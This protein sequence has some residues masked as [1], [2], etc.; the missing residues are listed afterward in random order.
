MS[1]TPHSLTS[2]RG[3]LL[4][5]VIWAFWGIGYAFF[6]YALEIWSAY[7]SYPEL[8]SSIVIIFILVGLFYGYYAYLLTR[9]VK[10]KKGIIPRIKL[11]I[12]LTPIFNCLLPA[13]MAFLVARNLDLN[14]SEVAKQ[15]Y[16]PEITGN[17]AGAIIMAVIWYFYFCL[18][19]RVHAIWPCSQGKMEQE[20]FEPPAS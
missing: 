11:W 4:F 10:K 16:P 19:K 17:I 15:M 8:L 12:F 3:W 20:K 14:F 1:T 9:L 5:Y 13:F 2:I 6:S 18:S 7:N